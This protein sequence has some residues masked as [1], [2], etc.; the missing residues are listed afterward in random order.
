[1]AGVGASV[2]ADARLAGSEA[3]GVA[4]RALAG[5][6]PSAVIVMA[7]PSLFKPELIDGIAE[8]F[9]DRAMIHGACVLRPIASEDRFSDRP[10]GK[11]RAHGEVEAGLAVL[12]LSGIQ[13]ISASATAASYENCGSS[14]GLALAAS[15]PDPASGSLI[16]TFGD[17][18]AGRNWRLMNP[19]LKAFGPDVPLI[20]ISSQGNLIICAGQICQDMNTALLIHGMFKVSTAMESGKTLETMDVAAK[21]AFPTSASET[22]GR[23]AFVM[24]C[25]GRAGILAKNNQ[26]SE[27]WRLAHEAGRGSA[28]FGGYGFGEIG[29]TATGAH[30]ASGYSVSIAVLDGASRGN[31]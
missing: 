24:N 1:V 26:L 4:L 25:G 13:T 15:K 27:E 7:S 20:G 23:V 22:G 17:Q 12:A 3:A 2:L 19:L 31:K 8:S 30:V 18:R 5:A 9:P 14:L 28:L 11:D 29:T 6:R 21:S 16:I 10:M